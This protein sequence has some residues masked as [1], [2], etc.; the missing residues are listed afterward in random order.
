MGWTIGEIL[1][2]LLVIATFFAVIVALFGE[3][4]REWLKR[5]KF[6]LKF[7][8]SS[9]R[10]FREATVPQD[11]IQN[12]KEFTLVKRQYYRLMVKNKGGLA[13]NVKV[14]IDI[15][16]ETGKELQYFEPSSLNWI[17][18]EEKEDLAKG[19]I[20]YINVCSQ[21]ID[22]E[23]YP[24]FVSGDPTQDAKIPLERRLR[25]ELHDTE[26]LR[27]IIWDR[28]L[29]DYK[30]VISF[31]GDNFEPITK[32]FVFNQPSSNTVPGDLVEEKFD[33]AVVNER[34]FY[35]FATIILLTA[36]IYLIQNWELQ[37]KSA[38]SNL[39]PTI[40]TIIVAIL[41]FAASSV[42][43]S[44]TIALQDMKTSYL[45]VQINARLAKKSHSDRTEGDEE[46]AYK[47]IANWWLKR[48]EG[49]AKI[50]KK[51]CYATIFLLFSSF[52]LSLGII[53]KKPYLCIFI[54]SLILIII[55]LCLSHSFLKFRKLSHLSLF[56]T[57]LVIF[58]IPLFFGFVMLNIIN[59][60]TLGSISNI[61]FNYW[62]F[63][64]A[65][66]SLFLAYK[67]LRSPS[68][69]I[70]LEHLSEVAILFKSIG[71]LYP[72]ISDDY[73]EHF[74]RFR[75]SDSYYRFLDC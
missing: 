39:S 13:K 7:D 5:P 72:N 57:C 46:D 33:N 67:S 21:V 34:K 18:G 70:F 8:K 25:I 32:Y 65:F 69:S 73:W 11:N 62:F 16:D 38:L 3:R 63:F 48:A 74:L 29:N 37:L 49:E 31:H 15:F 9:D 44:R 50:Q 56:S 14:K 12:E 60:I 10:C 24:R 45:Q 22:H 61:I 47:K 55:V 42:Y 35:C 27:G 2:L 36:S 64:I 43:N 30:F 51:N 40:L 6:D 68:K 1:Q 20:N 4:F 71:L 28:P 75:N 59:W 41:I 52:N 58:G 19:E 17:S 54:L 66:V 53:T 26:H 23:T